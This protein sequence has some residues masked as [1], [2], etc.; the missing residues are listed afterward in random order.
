MRALLKLQLC[1]ANG[2]CSEVQFFVR[3]T[4]AI[5]CCCC[6]SFVVAADG[7][8][9]SL[10]IAWEK[11][12]IAQRSSHATNCA[13]LFANLMRLVICD[14]S[15]LCW[16]SVLYLYRKWTVDADFNWRSEQSTV[17]VLLK[18]LYSCNVHRT[19]SNKHSSAARVD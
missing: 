19:E 9:G 6:S 3:T 12:R 7:C 10:K 4:L 11:R 8:T 1:R 18:V 5:C 2:L 14:P 16:C 13:C 15:N 17:L